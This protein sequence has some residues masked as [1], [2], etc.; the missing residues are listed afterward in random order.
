[1]RQTT[2]ENI[3]AS[4]ALTQWM[5]RR[6]WE[7]DRGKRAREARWISVVQCIKEKIGI[8]DDLESCWLKSNEQLSKFI[9]FSIFHQFCI[10]MVALFFLK[11]YCLIGIYLLSPSFNMMVSITPAVRL[12]LQSC[13]FYLGDY[14]NSHIL[15]D[16]HISKWHIHA[17][18]VNICWFCVCCVRV[19]VFFGILFLGLFFSFCSVFFS[20]L[21]LLLL[22][23]GFVLVLY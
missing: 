7:S 8:L 15:V 12:V 13:A 17:K 18:P 2:E 10:I 23:L 1:M 6:D 20:H 4:T 19:F 21:F 22:L 5:R 16:S 9:Q 3:Y 11:F 14:Y